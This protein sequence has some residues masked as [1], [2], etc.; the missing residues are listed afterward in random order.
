MLQRSDFFIGGV[1]LL[2]GSID[3][4]EKGFDQFLLGLNQVVVLLDHG[5]HCL[6]RQFG[7]GF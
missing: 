3:S 7:R 2:F 4:G 1:E 5:F 6:P